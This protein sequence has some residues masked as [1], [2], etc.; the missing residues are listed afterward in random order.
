M[1]EGKENKTETGGTVFLHRVPWI[2]S[3]YFLPVFFS[4]DSF[5]LT[6]R[7]ALFQRTSTQ[8]DLS[9]HMGVFTK[10]HRWKDLPPSSSP[11][12]PL[13]LSLCF[14]LLVW[15]DL[16]VL[17]QLSLQQQMSATLELNLEPGLLRGLRATSHVWL[18]VW[19][20][21]FSKYHSR[22]SAVGANVGQVQKCLQIYFICF[23]SLKGT[24]R[25][26]YTCRSVYSCII[27]Y[28]VAKGNQ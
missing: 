16:T 21:S 13:A 3:L 11:T 23:I 18:T 19:L 8:W 14:P 28:F 4:S 9:L 5:S 27:M 2:L 10:R 20:P 12:P 6:P 1:I 24:I 7:A 26:F 15:I 17:F 25:Q 22:P